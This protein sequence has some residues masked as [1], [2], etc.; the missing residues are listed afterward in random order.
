MAGCGVAFRLLRVFI[1]IHVFFSVF[2]YCFVLFGVAV[3]A[4]PHRPISILPCTPAFAP[5]PSPHTF[6]PISPLFTSF[7]YEI[8]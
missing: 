2:L 5:F 8:R 6:Q 1:H 7:V 4:N 3:S